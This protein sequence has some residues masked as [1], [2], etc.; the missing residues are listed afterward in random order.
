MS[1]SVDLKTP[2][3]LSDMRFKHLSAYTNKTWVDRASTPDV[4]IVVQFVSDFFG[5]MPQV[6]KT[7]DWDDLK[8]IYSHC[9]S[10]FSKA[11]FRPPPK[12][13][14][15]NGKQYDL[16]NLK[17][18]P[19]GWVA[20]ADLSDFMADPVRLACICYIPA[21]TKYGAIDEHHNLLHPISERHKEFTEHFPL[22]VYLPLAG[23]FLRAFVT[24]AEK[25]MVKAKA[26]MKAKRLKARLT[27]GAR[28]LTQWLKS[29][30]SSGTK[31][32]K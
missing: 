21:G 9:V 15:V 12:S 20:D 23:F 30:A 31:S 18:P 26:T 27:N 2:K 25:S 10:E 13:I 1:A 29:A 16:A 28:R 7:F 22:D 24:S 19:A 14:T 8:K 5:I 11:Q 3:R 17:K 6:V 32:R 4:H